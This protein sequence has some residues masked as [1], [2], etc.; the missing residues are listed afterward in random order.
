MSCGVGH[1]YGSD[2]KL[3][4]LWCMLAVEALIRPL[5][6]ELS[7]AMGAAPPK[8]K[9]KTKKTPDLSVAEAAN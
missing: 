2:P 1:R 5:V 3:L 9:T 8:K 6:W 4:W 7:Y